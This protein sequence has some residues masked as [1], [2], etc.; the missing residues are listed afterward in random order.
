[1]TR[2]ERR[3]ANKAA[4]VNQGARNVGSGAGWGMEAKGA[5]N[6]EA[7]PGR[8]HTTKTVAEIMIDMGLRQEA[9]ERWAAILRDPTHPH[10]AAM[11]DKAAT[12][13]DGAAAQRM[14]L[15]VRDAP[16][17]ELTDE[18][19]DAAIAR[20]LAAEGRKKGDTE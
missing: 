1:M 4:H 9:A 6:H 7:G 3:A 5:G 20:A 13:M 15:N 12:R 18:E 10:H 14:D 8:G 16:A 17:E 11:V 2:A 19:L